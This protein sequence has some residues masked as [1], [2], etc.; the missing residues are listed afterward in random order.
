MQLE[1]SGVDG[2]TTSET[3]SNQSKSGKLVSQL[4]DL[5]KSQEEIE[6]HST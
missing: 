2:V 1:E 5:L 6:E 4:N 3:Q